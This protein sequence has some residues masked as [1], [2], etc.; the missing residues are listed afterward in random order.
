MELSLRDLRADG[1]VSLGPPSNKG[2]SRQPSPSSLQFKGPVSCKD[3]GLEHLLLFL[4][5]L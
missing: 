5:F 2:Q 3:C 1:E 4:H